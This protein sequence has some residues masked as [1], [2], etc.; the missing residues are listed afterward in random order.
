MGWRIIQHTTEVKHVLIYVFAKCL[1]RGL[2]FACD[3]VFD[4]SDFF[5]EPLS[6]QRLQISFD[7]IRKQT[8]HVCVCVRVC[9]RARAHQP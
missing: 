6:S 4:I 7:T 3:Y 8:I 1:Y 5:T 9:V 2:L